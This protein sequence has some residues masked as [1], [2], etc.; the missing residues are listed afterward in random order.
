MDT[1]QTQNQKET[2]KKGDLPSWYKTC[3]TC[4]HFS[5][6]RITWYTNRMDCAKSI[7]EDGKRKPLYSK[8]HTDCKY[9]SPTAKVLKKIEN[10]KDEKL[11]E[12]A[13]VFRYPDKYIDDGPIDFD[14]DVFNRYKEADK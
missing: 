13:L 5:E 3:Y 1:H 12:M 4:T 14:I 10:A 11:S 2:Q 9:Y 6:E 7:L 8:E